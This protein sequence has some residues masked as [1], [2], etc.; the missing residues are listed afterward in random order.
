[1]HSLI[2]YLILMKYIVDVNNL[3]LNLMAQNRQTEFAQGYRGKCQH[4]TGEGNNRVL[5]HYY[6][7]M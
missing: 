3:N 5:E 6:A 2:V 4:F 7:R 1:M